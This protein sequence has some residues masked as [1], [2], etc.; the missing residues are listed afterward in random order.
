MIL[1]IQCVV[2]CLLFTLAILP[3][4]YKDPINM[5][6]SYPP[7]IRQRVEELPQ[8]KE[9]IKHREKIHIGKKILGLIFFVIILSSVAYLSGCRSFNTT[10]AHVFVL[11]FVVNI[12]DLI[13]LDWGIFCHSKKL[14]ISG[15]EDMEKEYKDYMFHVRGAC[16]GIVL[17]LKRRFH[18]D[19]PM[20]EKNHDYYIVW[21]NERVP[22]I[23]CK[24][25]D[26]IENW[27]DVLAVAFDTC[28]VDCESEQGFLIRE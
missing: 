7:K 28:F 17:G 6:M 20:I 3:T 9:T 4:Q 23:K 26:I 16:I 27:D 2:C 8:Y 25:N 13:V 21:D 18:S 10:F 22:I 5:I 12:Y 14:R 19:I 15:T 11:F 1:F 24:G